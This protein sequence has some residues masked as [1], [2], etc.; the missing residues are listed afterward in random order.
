MAGSYEHLRP[1]ADSYG[2]V[3]TSRCENMGDA[4][5][6]MTHMYWMIQ[7][8][9]NGDKTAIRKASRQ[10]MEIEAGRAIFTPRA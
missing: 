8:L 3:D 9:A 4:V 1:N 2:G 5:E 10:G 6:A 7:I